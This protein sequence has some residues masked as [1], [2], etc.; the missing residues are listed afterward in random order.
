MKKEAQRM[1]PT[2]KSSDAVLTAVPSTVSANAPEVKKRGR[3]SK[4][5]A[6]DAVQ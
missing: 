5:V 2:V 6:A 1:H 3:P 4:V